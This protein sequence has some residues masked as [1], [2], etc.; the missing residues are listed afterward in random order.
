MVSFYAFCRV[1]DD[2]ADD[3][4]QPKEERRARLN[5]WKEGL[6]HGFPEPDELQSEIAALTKKYS[7]KPEMLAE[8]V[9]GML[10]DLDTSRFATFEDLLKY[11]YKVAGVVGLVSIEIF[12]CKNPAS[13]DYAISLG[14]ALQLT[15]IIRDVGEDARNGRIYLPQADLEKFHLCEEQILQLRFD[16]NMEALLRFQ[17]GR[18]L[19]YFRDA[20]AVLPEEDRPQMQAAEMM[21]QIY[22]EILEKIRRKHFRVFDERIRLGKLR[23]IVILGAFF[24]RGFLRLRNS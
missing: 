7:I 12:G 13:K 22:S 11:C 19:Q 24:L 6:L 16:P 4:D 10:Q 21:A 8:I 14:Y 17:H 15:N 2:I 23:K 20:A 9:D 5:E 3:N 1:I 18:A